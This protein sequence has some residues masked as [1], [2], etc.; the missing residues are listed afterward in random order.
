MA[1]MSLLILM[2]LPTFAFAVESD[3]TELIPMSL[4]VMG[5]LVLVLGIV[6]LLYALL[7]KSG[8][9]IPVGKDREINLI[10]VRYLAPKRALYLIEVN[11]SKLLLSGTGDRMESL[12]QWPIL[13]EETVS[14]DHLLNDSTQSVSEPELKQ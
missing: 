9:W 13:E 3:E 8:R 14:F 5:S 2:I 10:E 11:G 4:K 7:K 6:L 1:R 12:A